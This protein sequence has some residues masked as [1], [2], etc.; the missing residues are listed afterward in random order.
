MTATML[1]APESV[2]ARSEE[3]LAARR[4]GISA[5]DIA[6]LLGLSPWQS[7][8]SLY[9]A[10]VNGWEQDENP[11]MRTGRVL[12][13]AIADW[14]WEQASAEGSCVTTGLWMHAT[15]DWMLATPDRI[16]QLDGAPVAVVE[17]KWVAYSWD[18][19]G[20]AGTG[21]VPVHYRA[22]VLWQMDVVGVDTGYVAAL[23]PDGFRSYLVRRDER[24]LRIMREAGRRFHERL[25]AGDPPPLDDAHTATLRTLKRLHPSVSDVDVQV[26]RDLAEGYRR[27]R[28]M[29]DRAVSLVD[30]YEIR[31]REE[32][33]DG[34]R[35]MYGKQLV[36]SRSV[37]DQWGD[38][39]ELDSLDDDR[40]VVDRLNPGRA[41]IYV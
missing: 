14:W 40:A 7:P 3:W 5:S 26:T 1:V 25:V 18:G 31:I 4:T 17:C 33:G 16:W 36:A 41:A 39:A 29:R 32:I 15:H 22:Q 38:M 35:A 23:G 12:E 28:A 10:K 37:F 21:D 11:D 13:P 8:F 34:R 20:E 2:A 19:W 24:D 6:A 9:W 27:A 30:R